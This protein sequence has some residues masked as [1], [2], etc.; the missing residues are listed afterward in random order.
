MNAVTPTMWS[1]ELIAACS[2]MEQ[3]KFQQAKDA[4][5]RILR[6]STGESER[7]S[8]ACLLAGVYQQHGQYAEAMKVL[9][10]ALG[11]QPNDARILAFLAD[12]WGFMGEFDQAIETANRSL[13]INPNNRRLAIQRACWRVS[14]P[15][16]AVTMRRE[17]E[18]WAQAY[19]PNPQPGSVLGA[20]DRLNGR[21]LRVGYVSGD[22]RRHA[23][24]FFVAPFLHNHDPKRVESH[25]FMTK[26]GD[27]YSESL[28]KAV[29]HWHDVPHLSAHELHGLV[30]EQQIDVLVDL[31]GHTS[32]DRLDTFYQR[33]APVQA[34]WFGFIPTL[35]TRAMDYRLTDWAS[36][37]DGAEKQYVETP[38]RMSC[39]TAY[40][41]P[42]EYNG[43]YASPFH[44]NGY[45]TM[46][47]LNHDRK[48][49]DDALRIWR[50]ILK[51]NPKAGLIIITSQPTDSG[52]REAF[53]RR[54]QKFNFPM[55]R[56]VVMGQLTMDK[57]MN[58]SSV[59]DFALD[60]YPISGGV[61][62]F[63]SLAMGL[64]VLTIRPPEPIALYAYSANT[65]ETVGMPECIADSPEAF[66]K[67]A[68]QWINQPAL[69]EAARR[70]SR[71]AL[72]ASPYMQHEARTRELESAYLDMWHAQT[73]DG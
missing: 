51:A 38:Y 37:P 40:E 70:K 12:L 8:A 33:A 31:S 69:I 58:L 27:H 60:S 43:P 32:G 49:G 23:V 67:L 18:Q 29:G 7:S 6:G 1:N 2:L 36:C 55:D 47:S 71:A 66:V 68:S 46:V 11:A 9:A 65:L 72:Q 41:M 30:R 62:T 73:M 5:Q 14:R 35:G 16:D 28:K 64:P 39:F 61:T 53:D 34:T 44:E 21:A 52:A 13:A 22:L 57:Y 50:S 25:V 63:H 10:R 56:V 17:F 26:G 59:A 45:I 19:M 20:S 4:L 3:D 54:L 42:G 48:I 24:Y 15:V